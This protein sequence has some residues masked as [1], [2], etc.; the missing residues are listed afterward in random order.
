MAELALDAPHLVELV[1][2][3]RPGQ[4]IAQQAREQLHPRQRVAHLVGDA[5]QHQLQPLVAGREFAP[6]LLQRLGEEADLV[7]G[8]GGD[9]PLEV[10]GPHHPRRLDQLAH[11]PGD[12]AGDQHRQQHHRQHAD[13]RGAEQGA[14]QV[15]ELLEQRGRAVVGVGGV[16]VI[17]AQGGEA[18]LVAAPVAAQEQDRRAW[19]AG[20]GGA[21]LGRLGVERVEAGPDG[22][23]VVGAGQRGAGRV[24]GVDAGHRGG[25]AQVDQLAADVAVR[26]ARLV[27]RAQQVDALAAQRQRRR[28]GHRGQAHAQLGLER[29]L[30]GVVGPQA[31]AGEGQ[32]RRR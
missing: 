8:A 12:A 7:G 30:G 29:S 6:H 25:G 19:L 11:R 31:E 2:L 26:A 24:E 32:Q 27:A 22:H 14:A 5:R 4:V 10:A 21:D 20:Q 17:D 16:A 15:A 23:A 1:G 18:A 9:R 3:P 28:L 13:H